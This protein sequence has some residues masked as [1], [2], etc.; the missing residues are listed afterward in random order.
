MV[1]WFYSRHCKSINGVLSGDRASPLCSAGTSYEEMPCDGWGPWTTWSECDLATDSRTRSR[2]CLNNRC[3]SDGHD[4]ERQSCDGLPSPVA[5]TSQDLIAVACICCFIV[6]AGFGAGIVIY[7]IK[8]RRPGGNGS[9]HYVSA[10][11]QNLYV[12]LPMLDLK[13]KHLSSNQS[14]CGTLRSTSTLRSKANSSIYNASRSEYETATIKRSH[15]QRNS[16][17]IAGSSTLMRADLD[18]DQLFTWS[19]K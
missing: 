3:D 18:S 16:S 11:S 5:S 17:L 2:Q 13:H 8:Y 14:D 1:F 9:P 7:F 15:S 12:S 10:K 6:G 19:Q 4:F